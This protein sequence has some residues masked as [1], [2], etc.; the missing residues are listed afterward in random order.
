MIFCHCDKHQTKSSIQSKKI[1]NVLLFMMGGMTRKV[2]EYEIAERLGLANLC[3][4]VEIEEQKREK[5]R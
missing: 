2:T 4:D 1:M 5:Q 3:G